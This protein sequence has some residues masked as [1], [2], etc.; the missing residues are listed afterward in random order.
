VHQSGHRSANPGRGMGGVMGRG[1]GADWGA[2][3][4][5]GVVTNRGATCVI[6]WC[7]E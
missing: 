4:G 7:H 3:M 2:K 6:W 1:G 5:D